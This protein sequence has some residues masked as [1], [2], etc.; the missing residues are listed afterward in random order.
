MGHDL[1]SPSKPSHTHK[2]Y[3]GRKSLARSCRKKSKPKTEG[4]PDTELKNTRAPV[5]PCSY[6]GDIAG[7]TAK[8]T[9]AV[10]CTSP[11]KRRSPSE[12]GRRRRD[13]RCLPR[14]QRW[15]LESARCAAAPTWSTRCFFMGFHFK[16]GGGRVCVCVVSCTHH[17]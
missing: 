1:R 7:G 5:L 14:E 13:C 6:S 9:H 8:A 16:G 3:P 2:P 12:C 4:T 11:L 10:E 17:S 15:H